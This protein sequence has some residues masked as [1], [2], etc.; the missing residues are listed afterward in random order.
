[1][2]GG[3]FSGVNTA[4]RLCASSNSGR[5]LAKLMPDDSQTTRLLFCRGKLKLQM[6]R[7]NE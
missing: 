7:Q 4:E 1:M 2:S 6:G 3:R 5:F